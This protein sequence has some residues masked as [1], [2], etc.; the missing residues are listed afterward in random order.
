MRV[1]LP[2]AALL[3]ALLASL[4][5]LPAASSAATRRTPTLAPSNTVIDGPSADIV[6]LSGLTVARDG[7]G[8]VVYLKDVGGVAH[9]FVS[10]LLNG[11]F[12]APIRVDAG[13]GGASSQPV[14]AGTNG[15]LMLVAFVNGGELYVVQQPSALTG[16]QAP[17]PL[18][19]GADNPSLSMSPFGKAYLAFTAVGD[20]GHDIRTAF[21]YQG[22]WAL[23]ATPLDANPADDSGTGSGRPQVATAGD[24][25]AIVAWGESGH[26]YTR[27]VLGTSPSIV[28]E[29]ADPSSVS[30][31]S[32]VSA[33]DPQV[34]GGGNSSY[35]SVAFEETVSLNGAQ[36][37]R[38]LVNRLLGSG[39]TGTG[40]GDGLTTPGGEGADQPRVAVQ[41]YGSGFVTSEHTQSHNLFAMSVSNNDAL[42]PVAQLNGLPEQSDPDAIP[43]TA[44]TISTLIAWQQDP[45]VAGGAEIRVRYAS[46]G[47][48][49]GP[50]QV[51]SSPAR[52]ST[53]AGQGLFA[54][55]DLAGDAAIAWVQGSGGQTQI[56][57][58]QLFQAP[59]GLT[60]VKL[61]R[62]S[63]TTQ[64]TLQWSPTAELWGAPRYVVR[65]GGAV[66]A[67]TTATLIRSPVALSQGRHSW[68]VTAVNL[69]G[70][71]NVSSAATMFIDSLAPRVSVKLSGSHHVGA[72]L[73]INVQYT[74]S[75]PGVP[76]SADSGVSSVAVKWGD[77]SKT[78]IVKRASHLYKRRG[79][80]RITVTVKDRAGNKT[81]K[82]RKVKIT[83]LIAKH[84]HAKPRKGQGH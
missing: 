42:G 82:T 37:T 35:G 70:L 40:G 4:L 45:G 44:G 27:R 29:R 81:V 19:Q 69:A 22:Q 47:S 72:A 31:W 24:G 17:V 50:E 21:F 76:R 7:T 9:V 18:L 43:A 68:Q 12:G 83:E 53:E 61:P 80:Y 62:Y 52:G 84:K 64:P 55:G 75:H 13:L 74:D 58:A 1:P 46:N 54:A 57:A 63:N 6:G 14:I 28:D 59:R 51:V 33:T 60:P 26:I 66:I 34:S 32:E 23:E 3:A 49:L 10:E 25:T 36:Q 11:S 71:T 67:S 8:A 48:S 73:R 65:V 78:V 30:G 79:R 38:V 39:Y 20:G 15:G 5:V 77:G 41:E 56:V 16:W 2:T